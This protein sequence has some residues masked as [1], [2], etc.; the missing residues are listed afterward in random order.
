[1]GTRAYRPGEFAAVSDGTQL[2]EEHAHKIATEQL[3]PRVE[4]RNKRAVETVPLNVYFYQAL[5]AGRRCSCFDIENSPDGQCFACFGTGWVGGYAKY[6]TTVEVVDVTHP[7][8]RMSNIMPEWKRRLR[9]SPFTLID[10]ALKGSIVTRVHLTTNIGV[11]DALSAKANV[12]SGRIDA[13]VKGPNDSEYVP[14]THN[15]MKARLFNPWVDIKVTLERYAVKDPSPELKTIYLRYQNFRDNKILAN[16]PR[17]EKSLAFQEIG[18]TDEWTPINFWLTSK[19]KRIT[20]EDFFTSIEGDTRWKVRSVKDFAPHGQLV[21]WDIDVRLI[22][23][24]E[25]YIHRVPA[26]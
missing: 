22:R 1:M 13:F 24:H 6:G 9:P 19:L 25:H 14:L 18:L 20:T 12:K 23:D 15:N 5:Q 3:I 11:V 7:D 16:V 26:E 8:I 17:V 21:S 2:L 4:E 10:G